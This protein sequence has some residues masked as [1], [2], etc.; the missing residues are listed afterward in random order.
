MKLYLALPQRRSQS[1]DSA[2]DNNRLL[3]KQIEQLGFQNLGDL[4]RTIPGMNIDYR[5]NRNWIDSLSQG[6]LNLF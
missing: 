1:I 6:F 2:Q 5:P 4:I 3:D